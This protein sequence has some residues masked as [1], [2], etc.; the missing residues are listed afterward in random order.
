MEDYQKDRLRKIFRGNVL[1]NV[2]L[3]DFTS[4]RVGGP[5]EVIVF[6]QDQE[7]L[8]RLMY[9]LREE[10]ISFLVL[11]EGTNLVIR[12]KGVKGV[13]V[14]LSPGL[15]GI[16]ITKGKEEEFYVRSKAGERLWHLIEV[17]LQHSLTGL[18]FASGIPGSVGGAVV[19]NAGAYGGEMKDIVRFLTILTPDG[20]VSH[21]EKES[22]RFSYRRLDLPPD[23]IV[24]M[25]EVALRPGSKEIIAQ[26]IKST[27]AKRKKRQPLELPSAGSVFKNPPGLYAAQLIEESGLKGY[28]IG[29]AQI[30]E[31]HANFIVNRGE[32]TAHNI[33]ELIALVQEKVWQTKGIKLEPEIR[34][35]GEG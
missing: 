14:K 34:V 5:A 28:R 26:D 4:F 24:L 13:V 32:A 22:L 16:E 7:D 29:G 21:L 2:L 35:V 23:A 8:I 33:L 30:S 19:M 6:P 3:K 18:E 12:D 17:A 31:R 15:L 27:L 9:F 10:K 25:V 20:S 1:F 11:G